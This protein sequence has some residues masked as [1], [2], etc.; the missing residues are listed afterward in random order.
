MSKHDYSP[1]AAKLL[2]CLLLW[3]GIA[4][5]CSADAVPPLFLTVYKQID[6]A[7]SR[8]DIKGYMAYDAPN[9][10]TG[11]RGKMDRAR[12]EQ[13]LGLQ[14]KQALWWKSRTEIEQVVL[15]GQS[16]RVKTHLLQSSLFSHI[17][18]DSPTTKIVYDLQNIDSWRKQNGRWRRVSSI[19]K[20]GT[21]T[22]NGKLMINIGGK[23]GSSISH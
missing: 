11:N 14:M 17:M 15:Q 4:C 5:A 12:A 13:T 23:A 18:P 22:N 9:F 6:A 20:R 16:A 3:S 10:V 1:Q 19:T 8:R 21:I 2:F 7:A